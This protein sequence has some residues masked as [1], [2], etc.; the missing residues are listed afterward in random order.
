MEAKNAALPLL[1]GSRLCAGESVFYNVPQLRDISTMLAILEFL[2]AKI[3]VDETTV[4]IDTTKVVSKPIPHELV[5]KLRG[6]IVVLG[7]LLARFGEV[8]MAYPGGCVLGKRPVFSHMSAFAQLGAK[9]CSTSNTLRLEG[10][11]KPGNVILPEFSVTATENILLAAALLDG[12]THIQLAAEEPHVQ[13]VIKFIGKRG[14]TTERTGSHSIKVYG[15]KTLKAGE[16][17]VIS[18]YLEAGAW[19]LAGLLT[20]G[21]LRIHGVRREDLVAFLG[22]IDR[23]KGVYYFDG[24]VLVVD[25][26]KSA[27]QAT[28]IQTN[29]FPGFPTDLQAPFGVAMTQAHGVSRVFEVLYEGR[30][31]YLYELEKMGAHI[32]ILNAHQALIIGPTPLV[33][34]TV[35]SND[36]RA[37]VAMV[38]AALAAQGE[39][40]ITDVQ[41]IERGYDHLDKKLT[42]L[43]ASIIREE[44][45]STENAAQIHRTIEHVKT[46]AKGKR[47]KGE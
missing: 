18:D 2:G 3:R 39:T 8:E 33:G 14:A 11:L 5:S 15:K 6:S 32:E 46:T 31:A 38:L 45:L 23:A 44:E 24:D 40:I 22:A 35:V 21:K 7:P 34:R 43:G 28:L 41:Y 47:R 29:I 10:T 27:L 20:H 19:V 17:T 12:T 16:H 37:G 30:M 36:I 26:E 25:G 4:R 1:A 13:D 9:D 42:E